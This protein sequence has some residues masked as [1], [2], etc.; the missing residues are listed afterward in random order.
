MVSFVRGFEWCVMVWLSSKCLRV[1]EVVECGLFVF[2][3]IGG[4]VCDGVVMVM[5]V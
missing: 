3:L 1:S 5:C 4:R 2:M